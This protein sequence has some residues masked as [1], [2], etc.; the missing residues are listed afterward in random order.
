[1]ANEPGVDATVA[2]FP[3]RNHPV[4]RCVYW[5]G[6]RVDDDRVL[7]VSSENGHPHQ[8]SSSPIIIVD[9]EACIS[10]CAE[11]LVRRLDKSEPQGIGARDMLVLVDENIAAET[12]VKWYLLPFHD[13]H[14]LV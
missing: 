8:R 11:V 2:A 7:E 9:D 1:M 4:N 3:P 5:T 10:Q 6:A 12:R 13:E 14:H